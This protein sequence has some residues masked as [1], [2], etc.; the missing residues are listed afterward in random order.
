MEE[1]MKIIIIHGNL[2][3]GSTLNED[4]IDRANKA[5]EILETNSYDSIL[6]TG[7]IFERF[8]GNISVAK[9]IKNYL[10]T[11]RVLLPVEIEEESL[12]TIHNVEL[13]AK[14]IN[15]KDEVTVVTSNYHVPRT[16]LAWR[17]IGKR[18]IK[19]VGANSKITPK[20]FFIEFIGI[21]VVIAYF[22]GFK[23]L[24]LCFRAKAR[25]IKA[26]D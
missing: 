7:G 16:W 1:I 23:W 9:A 24:E 6:V 4:S 17:L 22:L 2:N 26:I 13:S 8:Q 14:I 10:E 25:T 15:S 21:G 5:L 3:R 19:I 11:K 20:K 18:N 12:T